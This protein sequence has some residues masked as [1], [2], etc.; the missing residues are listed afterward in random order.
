MTPDPISDEARSL[1]SAI[2]SGWP[3]DLAEN[4]YALAKIQR[5]LDACHE[6][7]S[8]ELVMDKEKLSE[9]VNEQSRTITKLC[10]AIDPTHTHGPETDKICAYARRCR[11]F[12]EARWLMSFED[13]EKCPK[14]E[15]PSL[16]LT[17]EEKA[18]RDKPRPNGGIYLSFEDWLESQLTDNN[19]TLAHD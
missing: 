7:K 15:G 9:I 14:V 4:E 18:E 5:H 19:R 17:E 1:A 3:F 2:S 16:E 6:A 11:E 12:T 13:L 8:K 10:E